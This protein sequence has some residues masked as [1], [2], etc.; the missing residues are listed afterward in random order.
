FYQ[1]DRLKSGFEAMGRTVMP[2][3][4]ALMGATRL[5]SGKMQ[6]SYTKQRL[7]DST[8]YTPICESF[9]LITERGTGLL[10]KTTRDASP[11][12]VLAFDA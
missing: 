6:C 11:P 7:T 12:L 5:A 3:I 4:C 9:A 2:G 1:I 10:K 8:N